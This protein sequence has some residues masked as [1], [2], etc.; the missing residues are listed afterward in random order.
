V[1]LA[2]VDALVASPK[3]KLIGEQVDSVIESA[4]DREHHL[5]IDVGRRIDWRRV[6]INAAEFAAG[7]ESS[8]QT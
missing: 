3:V 5:T 6:E 8:V 4:N 1:V 7:L 2:L